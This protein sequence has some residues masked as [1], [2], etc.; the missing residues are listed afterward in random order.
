MKNNKGI[1]IISLI[2]TS[3]VIMIISS[4]MIFNTKNQIQL[5]KT[6]NLCLDIENLNSK[7]DDYYL[8]YGELPV[9]CKYTDKT[10]YQN[11]KNREDFEN[12]INDKADFQNAE[13]NIGVN[14]KD[15]DDYAVIDL[16]KLDSLS[17]NLG[18]D[19]RRKWPLW[20]N[21]KKSR[22]CKW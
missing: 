21:K 6:Q 10:K 14:S 1:T 4:A 12:I 3:I 7:I 18:Y 9:L 8:K 19:L 2:I 22:I 11:L 13:V 5:K 20:A 17:L 15:G 16:E